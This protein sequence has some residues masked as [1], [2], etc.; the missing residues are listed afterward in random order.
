MKLL[1]STLFACLC[2]PLASWAACTNPSGIEG[3]QIYNST[4]KTMQFCNGTDWINMG[5]SGAASGGDTFPSGII[6]ALASTT[7]PTGWSEYT[8]ARGVFL[9]G[10]DLSGG[11]T[12]DP[13]GTRTAGAFQDD[14]LE[15]HLHAADPASASTSS[16]GAHTHTYGT[17]VEGFG[18]ST[19]PIPYGTGP[20][21][22]FYNTSSAGAH[23]HTLDIPSFN[24]GST[25]AAETRPKNV[26]VL[27]CRKD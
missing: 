16:G 18:G 26:A 8:A 2:L 15:S 12:Y 19:G 9:R 25:G 22:S 14:A 7:C 13:S 5:V 11:T 17:S 20:Q 3:E 10:L 24:T 1:H 4:Y 23:T 6:V 21:M 27:Y